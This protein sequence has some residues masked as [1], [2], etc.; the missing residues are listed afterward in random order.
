MAERVLPRVRAKQNHPVR[1]TSEHCGGDDPDKSGPRASD[2]VT[3][4]REATEAGKRPPRDS[5]ILRAFV[6]SWAGSRD[7][8]GS[9]G[10]GGIRRLGPQG[11]GI[12]P[13]GVFLFFYPFSFMFCISFSI[14]KFT[15]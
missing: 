3:R 15:I 10:R 2:S 12:G 11:S 14:S 6:W 9:A 7:G 5:D 1:R 8:P 13:V 4:A